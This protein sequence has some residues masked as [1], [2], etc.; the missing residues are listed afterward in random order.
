MSL[1]PNIEKAILDLRNDAAKKLQ[2]AEEIE[3][4]AKAFPGLKRHV[5]RWN[6]IAYYSRSVN[7]K[8]DNY[9]IRHNCGCCSDSPL[10]IWPFIETESGRI[11]SDP[12][13]FMV[14]QRDAW[15]GGDEPYTG[16]D[17]KLRAVGISE[18]LIQRVACHF[19]PPEEEDDDVADVD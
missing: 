12:P 3:A 2:E 13:S 10:E 8:T 15:R 17:D 14:G 16:W 7:E 1:D 9:D 18:E 19:D 4:K 6:K 5:G 11:Y